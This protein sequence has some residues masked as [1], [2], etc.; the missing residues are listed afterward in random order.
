MDT[1]SEWKL[2]FSVAHGQRLREQL[3]ASGVVKLLT[4][5]IAQAQA[6]LSLLAVILSE[7]TAPNRGGPQPFRPPH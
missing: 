6:R 5:D 3:I 4:E 1:T 7:A 2:G